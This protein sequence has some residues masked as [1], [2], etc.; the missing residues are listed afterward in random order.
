MSKFNYNYEALD[1][2]NTYTKEELKKLY[3][4]LKKDSYKTY[5][6]N[7]HYSNITVNNLKKYAASS[8]RK[9]HSGKWWKR[10]LRCRK[11][12]GAI[13]GRISIKTKDRLP[14]NLPP[15]KKNEFNKKGL[16]IHPHHISWRLANGGKTLPRVGNTV[17]SVSHLCDNNCF[18]KKHLD[19]D[20]DHKRNLER[21]G[22]IG[23]LIV[24]DSK[25][26]KVISEKACEHKPPCMRAIIIDRYKDTLGG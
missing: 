18:S 8:K 20:T 21:R 24:V 9:T 13:G 6:V 15:V 3:K 19:S 12:K 16:R 14:A 10:R 2:L 4:F 23:Y 17:N 26:K 1:A 25:K 11:W 5:T 22:C 7:K